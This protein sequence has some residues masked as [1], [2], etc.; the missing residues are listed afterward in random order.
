MWKKGKAVN[1]LSNVS[2]I[3]ER[4]KSLS[5]FLG[6]VRTYTKSGNKGLLERGG[7]GRRRRRS[8]TLSPPPPF[9]VCI[10]GW[11]ETSPPARTQP[12]TLAERNSRLRELRSLVEGGRGKRGH[13]SA[14]IHLT[15]TYVVRS[16]GER[17]EEGS[18]G[19]S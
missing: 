8:E 11:R 10:G 1:S 2:I 3:R 18:G 17:K 7:A 5:F 12:K 6:F 9:V 15:Y 13:K 19:L 16:W 14:S 4:V